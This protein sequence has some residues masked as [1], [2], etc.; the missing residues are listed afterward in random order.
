MWVPA[1]VGCRFLS[2]VENME[3]ASCTCTLHAR[4]QRKI[5]SIWN[6]TDFDMIQI[7]YTLVATL[8]DA[9]KIAKTLVQEKLAACIKKRQKNWLW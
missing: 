7:T 2:F 5:D 6:A 4:K 9:K 1:L 3:T 8:E